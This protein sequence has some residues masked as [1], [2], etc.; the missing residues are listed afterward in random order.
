MLSQMKKLIWSLLVGPNLLEYIKCLS[1]MDS[2][3]SGRVLQ[4]KT[5]SINI[6]VQG[7]DKVYFLK[8]AMSGIEEE[9]RTN[10]R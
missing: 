9:V 5:P 7:M 8:L 10:I 6:M 4:S 3:H 2:A 1:G